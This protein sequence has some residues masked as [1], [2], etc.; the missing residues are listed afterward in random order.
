MYA[1]P[2]NGYLRLVAVGI[3]ATLER[4]LVWLSGRNLLYRW[5]R[6]QLNHTDPVAASL[7][8]PVRALECELQRTQRE[9]DIL[10]KRWIFSADA[11]IRG[12]SCCG[13]DC[14]IRVSAHRG[15]C[16]SAFRKRQWVAGFKT[17]FGG[18]REGLPYHA[19][20]RREDNRR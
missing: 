17:P 20:A 18:L 14:P 9:R 11:S 10:N 8:A 16:R 1:R 19:T 13:N 5:K 4:A 6:K 12:L 2:V 3:A 7:E 15:R